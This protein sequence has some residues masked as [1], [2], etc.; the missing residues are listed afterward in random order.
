M[1]CIKSNF[2]RFDQKTCVDRHRIGQSI[3]CIVWN[4]LRN[5][6]LSTRPIVLW[7]HIGPISSNV[8]CK[9]RIDGTVA[10]LVIDIMTSAI[11]DPVAIVCIIG[12]STVNEHV[13]NI[14]IGECRICIEHESDDTRNEWCGTAC[15][16]EIVVDIA[17]CVTA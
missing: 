1:V 15:T 10:I 9:T 12:S 17:R 11:C 16:T 2:N 5:I 6:D 4:G 14:S 7:I 8:Y 3:G 13:L